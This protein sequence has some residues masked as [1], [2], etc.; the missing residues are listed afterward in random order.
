M[1]VIEVRVFEFSV[2]F[3][4]LF[5]RN[6]REQFADYHEFSLLIFRGGRQAGPGP[7]RRRVRPGPRR[8][9]YLALRNEMQDRG[10]SEVGA[11]EL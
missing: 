6:F 11:L 10:G 7:F 5:A 8:E 4:H 1:D 9:Q 2:N 3:F